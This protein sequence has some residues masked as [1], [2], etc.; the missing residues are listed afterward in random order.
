[1]ADSLELRTV[2]KC[3]PELVT[4]LKGLDSKLVHFLREEGFITDGIHEKV[5]NVASLLSKAEKASELVGCI[6]DRIEQDSGSY[7]I[8]LDWL[9]KGPGKYYEPIVKKLEAE[10]N[11][12]S[13]AAVQ[14]SKCELLH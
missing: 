12:M 2:K 4:A 10:F 13:S 3:S 5:T 7:H 11:R 8:F 9:K 6:E 1:M 14:S